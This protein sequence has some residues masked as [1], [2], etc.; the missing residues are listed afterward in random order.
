MTL[1]NDHQISR[2]IESKRQLFLQKD[3]FELLQWMDDIEFIH[4]ELNALSIIEKQP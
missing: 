3:L 2:T 4:T 1:N